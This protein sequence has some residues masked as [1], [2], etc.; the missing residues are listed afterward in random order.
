[1]KTLSSPFRLA[2]LGTASL[3]L[4]LVFP[5][6]SRAQQVPASAFMEGGLSQVQEYDYGRP[7]YPRVTIYL[8]GN[9]Q[10]GMWTVEQG[11][12]FLEYLSVAA[13]GN[14][15]ESADTRIKN[16]IRLYRE[17]Q[18]D[19]EPVFEARLEEIFSRKVEYPKLQ[20]G[21]VLIVE[22][23][24]RRRFFTFRNMSQVVGTVASLVSLS[25]LVFN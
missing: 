22:S 9:A 8:W 11:T 23:I 5:D 16:K 21:D 17:G 1:M 7:G 15:N 6:L 19:E 10:N 18:I 13:Q 4:V 3:F 24:Q 14:F 2:F 12:N 25:L 20:N